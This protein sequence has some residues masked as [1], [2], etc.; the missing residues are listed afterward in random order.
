VHVIVGDKLKALR[1]SR[2][3][4]LIASN[5]PYLPSEDTS[6]ITT[7][8]GQTGV[9]F[10]ISLIDESEELLRMGAKLVIIA[11]TLGNAEAI[12]KHAD[13][14]GLNISLIASRHL[15]FEEI[16]CYMLWGVDKQFRDYK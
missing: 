13:E 15:F 10:A 5:P 14:R 16:R 12:A 11:S 1:P 3:I 8:G 4:G 2:K 6:D 7:E 9:E